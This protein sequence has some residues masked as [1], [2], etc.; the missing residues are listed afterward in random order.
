MAAVDTTPWQI[1]IA[2]KSIKKR[3]KLQLLNKT[4]PIDPAR[5]ALD[6]GCAQGTLSWFLRKKGGFWISTDEDRANLMT[7]RELLGANLVRMPRGL[8]PF[9]PETF[10]LVTC[11]DYLE[12]IEN[13]AECLGEIN[14]VLK[15]GG[16]LVVVTPHTGRLF[17]LHRLRSALG[18]KLE[19]YGHKREGYR[20]QE[21]AAM[22]RNAGFEVV[23]TRTYSKFP[24]EFIE[25]VL[26][27]V[28]IRFF[29][30]KNESPGTRDGHIKPSTE[31]EYKAQKGKLR[32]YNT[33]YPLVW[34]V[35]RLDRLLF[36]LK[37]YSVMI[38]A[39]KV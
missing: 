34:L 20:R 31:E 5:T 33:V 16:T 19:F 38:W 2:S 4:I 27:W 14:R 36:F 26:N 35:S 24:S 13:D 15:K 28:Y 25:L 7:S 6:I 23:R 18:L 8:L 39:R 12:H 22:I 21:L 3:D 11:L 37:G 29:S 1:R 9:R 32:I 30:A 10:D 17:I